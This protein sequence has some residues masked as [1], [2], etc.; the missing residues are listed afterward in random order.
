MLLASLLF[1]AFSAHSATY[2][3]DPAH[4]SVGFSVKH[5]VVSKTKGHFSKFEGAFNF[6]EKKNEVSK[7]DVKIDPASVDTA[8]RKR[9]DHLNSPDF[10]DVKKYPEMKFKSD[11]PVVVKSGQTVP[12]TGD[13]AMHGV[14]KPVTLDLTYGGT[15]TDP[16]GKVRVGFTLAGK[17]NRKDWGL[18]WNKNLDKGGVAVGDEVN[19]EIEGEAIKD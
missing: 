3:M 19:I 2:K 16:M 10:F 6:D 7:V 5:M 17:I 9:D 14:T 8:D 4:S 13:L 18:A 11:K 1:L 12:V 15:V